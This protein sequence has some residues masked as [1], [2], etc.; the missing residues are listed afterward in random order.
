[1]YQIL[2]F[3]VG[4]ATLSQFDGWP[5]LSS[6]A[7]KPLL[8]NSASLAVTASEVFVQA[9]IFSGFNLTTLTAQVVCITSMINHSVVI[10]IH[11][12]MGII[13]ILCLPSFQSHSNSSSKIQENEATG[14][15]L[16]PKWPTQ[17]WWPT[18]MRMVIQ[19]PLEL[20]RKNDLI[21]LPSRPDLVHPLHLKPGG[22]G[23]GYLTHDWV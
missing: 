1:M 8:T 16:I 13:F 9:F 11:V 15:I 2:G 7:E 3:T 21:F 22:G 6:L 4:T 10:C 5:Y 19:I 12:I 17:P 14:V 20:P 23:G 18:L